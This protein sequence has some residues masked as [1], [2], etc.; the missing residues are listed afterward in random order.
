MRNAISIKKLKK[1]F[2][3]VEVFDNLTV[4]IKEGEITAIFGPNGCGKSTLLDILSGIVEKDGGTISIKNFDRFQFS[5]IFQNYR[6]SLLLWRK[7]LNN[8]GFPLEIQN[9]NTALITNRVNEIQK[10]FGFK[11]DLD[12]YPYE[13]SGGQQQILAFFQALITDPTLLF[14][15]EPFSALDYENNIRLRE[16]LL[17]YYLRYKPTIVLITHNI[18]EAVHLASEIVV[19]SRKPTNVLGRIQ[20][21]LA[22]PRTLDILKHKNFYRIKNEVLRLFRAEVNL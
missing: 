6:D 14:I 8:I 13:L 4:D 20:N 1:R 7:N 2:G 17:D 22:Y 10:S 3:K 5:Y 19:L 16:I 15:D 21:P 11:F 12:K 18:E 9:L